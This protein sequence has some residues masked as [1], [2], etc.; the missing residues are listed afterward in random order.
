MAGETTPS[1]PPGF[2]E[3]LD[4]CLREDACVRAD[5]RQLKSQLEEARATAGQAREGTALPGRLLAA[6]G[7][8][9]GGPSTPQEVEA[10]FAREKVL[11]RQAQES[12]RLGQHYTAQLDSHLA[13]YLQTAVPVFLQQSRARVRLA[14]WERIIEDLRADL[15]ELI[16]MLGQAR[17]N[18]VA[19]YDRG[20]Q[21][22]S[23]TAREMFGQSSGLIR[24]VDARVRQANAKAAEL[25]GLPGVTIIPLQETINNLMKLEITTMLREF[26]RVVRELETFEQRQLV[27]LQ[28]PAV[29]ATDALVAQSQAYLVQ[30][31][32]QLRAHYDLQVTPGE[33]AESI[34]LILD[35]FRRG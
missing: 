19:G 8:R 5:A 1:A 18:A 21:L 20:T 15:R 27:D 24:S 12:E 29:A 7:R 32:G 6:L 16:K 23:A 13:A 10:A 33:I 30:Y 35:R 34:P 14:E 25:G 22:M 17:N 31:R 3:A 11:Q 28:V 4:A 9:K 2:P 26:D